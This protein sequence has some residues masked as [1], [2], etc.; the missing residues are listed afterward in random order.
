[1]CQFGDEMQRFGVEDPFPM[2][3]ANE[4]HEWIRHPERASNL[5]VLEN[6]GRVFRNE[7]VAIGAQMKSKESR[8]HRG[9]DECGEDQNA[10]WSPN[11]ELVKLI[12][13]RC[14]GD[15]SL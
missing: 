14:Q 15:V 4:N 2:V 7:R 12:Q 9:G 8:R 3:C 5:A 13:R 10:D 6:R 11:G 1:V